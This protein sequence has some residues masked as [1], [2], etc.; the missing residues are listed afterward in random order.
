M[1]RRISAARW[2]LDIVAELRRLGAGPPGALNNAERAARAI[3][4][5]ARQ[6]HLLFEIPADD[7]AARILAALDDSA[8]ERHPGGPDR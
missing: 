1:K 3:L 7:F 8:G 2:L 5:E 4:A 6:H